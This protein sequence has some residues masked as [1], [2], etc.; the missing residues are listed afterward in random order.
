MIYHCWDCGVT[1][2]SWEAVRHYER[3][4]NWRFPSMW[5]DGESFLV[6]PDCHSDDIEEWY[7]DDED[8][9]EA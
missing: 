6:C 5:E 7:E 8:E 2:E 3:V 9:P 1:F 4:R